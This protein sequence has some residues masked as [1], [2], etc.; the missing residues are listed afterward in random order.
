MA[1]ARGAALTDLPERLNVEQ[2]LTAQQAMALK[3][4]GKSKFWADV[5]A[6]K[7]PQ[8]AVR[9][10][11]FVRWRAGDLLAEDAR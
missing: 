7:L 2:L 9:E 4:R 3:G 10:G 6:G 8:P 5:K 11:R 1:N